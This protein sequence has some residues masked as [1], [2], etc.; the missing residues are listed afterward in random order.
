MTRPYRIFQHYVQSKGVLLFLGDALLLTGSLYADEAL[1]GLNLFAPWFDTQHGFPTLIVFVLLG[2][3]SFYLAGL[4]ESNPLQSGK[5]M[6][7]RAVTAGGVWVILYLTVGFSV[8]K[9][10]GAWWDGSSAV[11][12]GTLAVILLRSV[13]AFLVRTKRFRERVLFLGVTPTADRLV[14]EL[15]AN[16]P[17]YEILGYVDD[18]PADQLALTNGFRVLGTT[19]E[20][21]NI[22]ATTGVGTI[23]VCL[24]ERRGTFPL[25]PILECKLRGIR[26]EDWPAFYEKLT[27]KIVVQ[28][29]RTSW[30]V[31]SEGFHRTLAMRTMKRWIDLVLAGLFL[32]LAG[33]LLLLVAVAIRLNSPGPIFFRQE[34]VGEGGRT[35]TLLKFRTMLENAEADS[36]PV[37][38]NEHDPR[39]TWIGRWLRRTRLDEIPQIWNVFRGEMS[40]I[41]PRPERPHFVAQLQEKIPY[42]SERHSIKPG[43]TGWAQVRY[44]Y[45]ASI[46]DAEEKLQYD[47]YY[48]KN[49]S[50]FL[51]ALILCSSI[52]VVLFGKGAR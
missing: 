35:F 47:L 23:V 12:I 21:H 6:L 18:R 16:H 42:Y 33:P 39:V 14:R 36:G 48:V 32:A 24:T 25:Q 10:S 4:Y 43:I 46:E 30:L 52:Q 50:H 38:A 41:G 45:G 22:A 37:W 17:G 26:I 1:R 13:F 7:V 51:D 40:F 15:E 2:I 8:R 27:G 9:E 3:M 20:L 44:Q 11:M 19:R 49:M 31:F 34:R 29:L 5:E 28:D